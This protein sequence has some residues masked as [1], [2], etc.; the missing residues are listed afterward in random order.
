MNYNS[1]VAYL[2]E[3]RVFGCDPTYAIWAMRFALETDLS[4]KDKEVR[5]TFVLGAAQWILWYG[6]SLFKL[7]SQPDLFEGASNEWKGW[8]PG[9]LYHGKA[10]LFLD[11][12]Q[13]WKRRFG[14]IINGGDVTE[15]CREVNRRVIDLIET[16]ER[17]MLL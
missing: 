1:F 10:S 16:F 7:T 5:S 14:D 3:Q 11:R 13:F 6:Q 4:S 12:W 8:E 9:P 17:T 15:E 2:H